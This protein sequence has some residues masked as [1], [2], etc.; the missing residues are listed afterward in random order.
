MQ[1]NK[2]DAFLNMIF[3]AMG[4]LIFLGF[5]ITSGIRLK[6]QNEVDPRHASIAIILADSIALILGILYL[7]LKNKRYI[8]I[9]GKFN[10]KWMIFEFAGI[11]TLLFNVILSMGLMFW[12]NTNETLTVAIIVSLV[13]IVITNSIGVGLHEYSYY[14]IKLDL[15]KLEKP[16]EETKEDESE[17]QPKD[18]KTSTDLDSSATAGKFY[19]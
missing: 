19:E 1:F 5:C 10:P 15:A 18:I 16:E 11:G 17:K 8:E 13:L 14:K 12:L 7:F 9:K 2:K 6:Y 3:I 4:V